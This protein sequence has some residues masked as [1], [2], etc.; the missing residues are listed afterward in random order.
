MIFIGTDIV[1]ISRI[2]KLINEKGVKFLHHLYTEKE[3]EYCRSKAE[4]NQHYAGKFAAKEAVKKAVL[5]Y[6]PLNQLTLRQIEVLNT[7]S[8][9]PKVSIQNNYNELNQIN[10]SISHAGDYSIAAAVLELK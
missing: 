8:G 1:Q 9:E 4:P 10:V 6:N 7:E 5:S 3:Q 2:E